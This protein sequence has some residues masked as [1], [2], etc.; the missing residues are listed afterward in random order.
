MT[1]NR[2]LA[3]EPCPDR[4][5]EDLGGAFG[6]GCIGGFLWHFGKGWRNSPSGEKFLGALYSSR[7]RAPILGGNFAVWGGTFSTFDCA[8]QYARKKDDYW[9]AIASGAAT[10]GLL[11]LRGGW[12]VASKQA[13]IG[14]ILLAIIEGVM[15]VFSRRA[16]STPRDQ[17]YQAIEMEKKMQAHQATLEKSA[18]T[19]AQN[20]DGISSWIPSFFSTIPSIHSSN[21]ETSLDL[22]STS[23]SIEFAGDSGSFGSSFSTFSSEYA[24]EVKSSARRS[25]KWFT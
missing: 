23:P 5:V 6:M 2:D 14:G 11:A 13:L 10:G 4:I 16:A 25:W 1:E 7:M 8:F 24:P 15:V 3:R 9:N 19:A 17:Y 21:A 12:R 20:N 18:A 22:A